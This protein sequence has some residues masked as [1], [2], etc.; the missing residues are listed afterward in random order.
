ME[1]SFDIEM[2]EKYGVNEAI[3]I[4]NLSFWIA[5]NKANNKHQYD[6]R[7]WT[8]NSIKAFGALFPFWKDDKIRKIMESLKEQGVIITGNYNKVAYDR[9]LWYAF[10][11]EAEFIP[12]FSGMDL[13]TVAEPI[14]DIN[15]DSKTDTI[16]KTA[17]TQAASPQ[18]AKSTVTQIKELFI[19]KGS[20]YYHDGKEAAACKK[21]EGRYLHDPE[22]FSQMIDALDGMRRSEPFYSKQPLSPTT[23]N[24]YWNKIQIQMK[25]GNPTPSSAAPLPI[26]S[27]ED[28]I[29]RI[30]RELADAGYEVGD[31]SLDSELDALYSKHQK[32]IRN[33][34]F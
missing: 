2:A 25:K 34:R 15:T 26:E 13:D 14:P 4:K 7:T 5:K 27:W 31:I 8:Y 23:L 28:Y 22:S 32:K 3:V 16:K 12:S 21:L 10:V 18:R 9:T 11:K 1:Y 30:R 6:G 29:Y 20:D 17:S 24:C 33:G 19:A